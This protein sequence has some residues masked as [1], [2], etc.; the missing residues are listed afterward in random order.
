MT[1]VGIRMQALKSG[2]VVPKLKRIDQRHWSKAKEAQFIDHLTATCNVAASLREVGMSDTTVYRHRKKSAHFRAAWDRALAEGYAR[3]EAMLLDRAINGKR[4]L[5]ERDGEHVE[6]VEYSDSLALNLLA[7]HR[8]MVA[9]IRAANVAPREDPAMVR[10]RIVAQIMTV[11]TSLAE[12]SPASLAV[13]VA[14]ELIEGCDR[15]LATCRDRFANVANFQGEPHL[16]GND[17]LTRYGS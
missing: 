9:D 15:Q 1:E 16:P 17:L 4:V 2:Q 6:K 12:A 8:R 10:S 3:L 14:V 13:P 11:V 7:Q 5:V